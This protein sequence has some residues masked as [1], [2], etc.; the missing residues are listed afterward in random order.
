L[1][2]AA[3]G[4]AE[5]VRIAP[6]TWGWEQLTTGGVIADVVPGGHISMLM[7]PQ[8]SSL[9]ARLGVIL[10]AA[11]SGQTSGASAGA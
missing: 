7:R 2:V 3:A 5:D 4:Q 11:A 6:A 10:G 8:V 1:R 9:A